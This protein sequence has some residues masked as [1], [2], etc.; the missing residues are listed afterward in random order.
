VA[1]LSRQIDDLRD[2]HG[3]RYGLAARP[4]NEYVGH[5]AEMGLARGMAWGTSA[6]ALVVGLLG[7][8]NTM[9]MSVL[10]RTQEFGILKALGWQARRVVGMVLF[11]SLLLTLV[12]SAI[13]TGVG[14]LA[15]RAIA[16]THW[17]AGL[18]DPTFSLELVALS[19]SLAIVMGLVAS[20]VPSLRAA[21]L[22]PVEA[23]HYE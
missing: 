16:E 1:K 5:S 4:V 8:L 19:I 9:M 10:E 20:L 3:K 2:E 23:L 21:R 17:L 14:W 11:E 18:L 22:S 15:T 6:I 12:G 7:L 13:G